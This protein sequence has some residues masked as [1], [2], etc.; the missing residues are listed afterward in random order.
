VFYNIL[1]TERN[2]NYLRCSWM[3]SYLLISSH[4]KQKRTALHM[5]TS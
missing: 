3:C 2:I 1:H 5:R 4:K